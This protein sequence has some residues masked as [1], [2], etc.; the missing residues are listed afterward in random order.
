MHT[1]SAGL[2]LS[3]VSMGLKDTNQGIPVVHLVI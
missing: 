1:S 3:A 2:E